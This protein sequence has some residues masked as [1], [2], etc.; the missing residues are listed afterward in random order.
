MC[1]YIHITEYHIYI[2]IDATGK[3]RFSRGQRLWWLSGLLKADFWM[4]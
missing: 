3:Y 2:C 1:I 4:L